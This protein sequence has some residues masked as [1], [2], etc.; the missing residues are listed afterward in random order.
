MLVEFN[1]P[2]NQEWLTGLI[3]DALDYWQFLQVQLLPQL[4]LL[5]VQF[6]LSHF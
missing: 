5:Q 6:G 1:K 2:I 4:Q 3:G